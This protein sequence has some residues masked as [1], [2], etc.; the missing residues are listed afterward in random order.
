MLL[1]LFYKYFYLLGVH[2]KSICCDKKCSM[3]MNCDGNHK[4]NRLICF[5]KKKFQI[6]E[7]SSKLNSI[8][9]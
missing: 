7:I 4:T 2:H 3:A 9:R 5:F 1:K 8:L 6:P